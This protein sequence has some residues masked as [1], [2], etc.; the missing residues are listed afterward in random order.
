M[1]AGLI[2]TTVRSLAV[3]GTTLFAGTEQRCVAIR[4]LIGDPRVVKT[5]AKNTEAGCRDRGSGPTPRPQGQSPVL[6]R[7]HAGRTALCPEMSVAPAAV[8]NPQHVRAA[9]FGG[10]DHYSFNLMMSTSW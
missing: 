8:H 6:F 9:E 4:L 2:S 1:N 7:N 5:A 3:K 10:W